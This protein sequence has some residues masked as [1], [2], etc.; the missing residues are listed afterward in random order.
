MV[1]LLVCTENH[2]IYLPDPSE[3]AVC[4]RRGSS[5]F[6]LTEFE[7]IATADFK[8]QFSVRFPAYHDWQH[9]VKIVRFLVFF[10]SGTAIGPLT[11]A[12]TAS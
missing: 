5:K 6:L 3:A 12:R 2:L 8:R 7:I 11:A 9:E 4:R 10:T 1:A